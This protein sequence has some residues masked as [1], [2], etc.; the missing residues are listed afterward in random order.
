MK[1]G[2]Y[3]QQIVTEQVTREVE[4]LVFEEVDFY[5]TDG[6]L[7]G[8]HKLCRSWTRLE[9]EQPVLDEEG[10]PVMVASGE[11]ETVEVPRLNPAYDPEKEY[12]MRS[13]RAEWHCVGL[14]GQLPL[15][16]GQPTAPNWIKV[17]GVSEEV[18]IWLVK[19]IP[20]SGA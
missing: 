3:V 10:N 17:K 15:T 7:I 6:N 20:F 14:I 1:H 16:K 18:E 2:R 12:T 11:M 19:I 13:E 8:K 5:D 9:E 4:A